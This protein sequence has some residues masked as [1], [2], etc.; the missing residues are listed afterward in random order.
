[1]LGWHLFR[2]TYQIRDCTQIIHDAIKSYIKCTYIC[3]MY[4]VLQATL[5]DYGYSLG[6]VIP[7]MYFLVSRY[8]WYPEV[9]APRALSCFI[10]TTSFHNEMNRWIAYVYVI[11]NYNMYVALV[12]TRQTRFV[13]MTFHRGLY[14]KKI[15]SHCHMQLTF[16]KGTLTS[17]AYWREFVEQLRDIKKS[18]WHR[19][20]A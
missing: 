19:L 20:L 11:H 9:N 2:I 17:R 5:G 3:S 10:R 1:M 14:S 4:N 8:G 13:S 18:M 16:Y 7:E 12:V 15:S 6:H